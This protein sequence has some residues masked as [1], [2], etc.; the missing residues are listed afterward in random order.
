MALHHQSAEIAA[1]CGESDEK[2]KAPVPPSVEKI[3][4][5]Y[6]QQ[7]LPVIVFRHRP[8]EGEDYR[9]EYQKLY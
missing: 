6:H 3:T 9:E 8:V 5:H 4:H 1:Q 7:V 2:Q